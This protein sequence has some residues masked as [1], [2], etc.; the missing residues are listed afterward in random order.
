MTKEHST[1]SN[2]RWKLTC[3]DSPE[4]RV[5][6]LRLG[7]SKTAI[8]DKVWDKV[9]MGYQPLRV[10]LGPRRLDFAFHWP[11]ANMLS[12]R[13]FDYLILCGQEIGRL[14]AAIEML[15]VFR[16]SVLQSKEEQP[17]DTFVAD[18]LSS[19]NFLNSNSEDNNPFSDLENDDEDDESDD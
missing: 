13:Y 5:L 9:I 14:S 11:G 8:H 19:G 18:L 16:D 17:D 12:Q 3:G 1:S 6:L 7:W 15:P 2:Y 10:F 4:L